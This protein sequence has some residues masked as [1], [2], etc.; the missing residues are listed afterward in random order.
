LNHSRSR[1]G[2]VKL[3]AQPD[4][5]IR[6]NSS[7]NC[8]SRVS[9]SL[10]ASIGFMAREILTQTTKRLMSVETQSRPAI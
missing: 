7:A 5:G 1:R 6:Y 8:R 10:M 2:W 9:N 4:G 3:K